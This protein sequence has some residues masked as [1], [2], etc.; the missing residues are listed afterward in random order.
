[1]RRGAVGREMKGKRQMVDIMR[2]RREQRWWGWREKVRIHSGAAVGEREREREKV[3]KNSRKNICQ[4]LQFSPPSSQEAD[5]RKLN[6]DT[7]S[8]NR[9]EVTQDLNS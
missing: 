5:Y 2:R 4:T 7:G 6:M 8:D 9:K 3:R 1:M